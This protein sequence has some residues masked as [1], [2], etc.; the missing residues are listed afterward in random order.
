MAFVLLKCY[1]VNISYRMNNPRKLII[2]TEQATYFCLH[3]PSTFFCQRKFEL[4]F[5]H[6]WGKEPA[7]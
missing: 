3:L 2:G 4:F 5:G 1:K 7:S 6:F